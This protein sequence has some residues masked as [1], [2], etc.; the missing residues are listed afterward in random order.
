MTHVF[1]PC[2]SSSIG[3]MLESSLPNLF[4][5]FNRAA[6]TSAFW[7]SRLAQ[8]GADPRDIRSIED[9]ERLAPLDKKDVLDD[10]LE[11]G[12]YGTLLAV[13]PDRLCRIHRTSGTTAAPFLVLMTADDVRHTIEVGGRAFRCAGVDASDVVIHC[14][15]YCMW[16]GGMTDHQ[17]LETSGATVVPFGVGNSNFLVQTIL[18]LRPTALSCTP[19]YL[20]RLRQVLADEFNMLPSELGLNKVLL[21]GEA[22]LQESDIRKAIEDTWDVRAVDANYGLSD[23]LSIVASECEARHGLHFHGQGVLF[24]ELM[25]DDGH[26]IEIAPRAVG[27]LVLSTLTREAQP[28]FRYR[29]RDVIQIVDTAAC[30]CGRG[31]FRFKV[32]GRSDN[33]VTVKGVNFFPEALQGLFS[34]WP[35]LSGEYRVHA[36]KPPVHQLR[37]EVEKAARPGEVD[38][39]SLAADIVRQVSVQHSVKVV[40]EF[41]PYGA[42]PK[43]DD[44]T[45]RLL[46]N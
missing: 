17:C 30:A 41:V 33:M 38:W 37:V 16:S 40:V 26:S 15:N 9:F 39:Q 23:V 10:Q 7:Q 25:D 8:H 44:K 46:R 36:S 13:S 1:E 6:D 21:G 35:Q 14:L 5:A 27:E 24:P 45:Q 28:L 4:R 18:R 42:M 20:T 12:P 2:E 34:R 22:G 29:T 11:H 31:G 32:I 3:E 43:T 19:S